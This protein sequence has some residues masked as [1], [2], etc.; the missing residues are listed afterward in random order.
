MSV[1]AP[2]RMFHLLLAI[3]AIA[4]YLTGELGL[5]HIWVGY[6]VTALIAGRLIWGALG[7]RALGWRKFLP[8]GAEPRAIDGPAR[9][10]RSTRRCSAR[11][12]PRCSS[13]SGRASRSTR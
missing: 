9:I 4:S 13:L 11:S 7:P 6:A 8:T 10:Q 5:V 12:W 3:G 2:I 1:V